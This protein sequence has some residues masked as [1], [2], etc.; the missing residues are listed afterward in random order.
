[1]RN[2]ERDR[3]NFILQGSLSELEWAP[4]TEEQITKELFKGSNPEMMMDAYEEQLGIKKKTEVKKNTKYK[5][6]V[7]NLSDDE[8]GALLDQFYNNP[9][10]FQLLNRADYWTH[11]G[12][13]KVLIEY[14]EDLDVRARK[15][16][17]E[18]R[19]A[20]KD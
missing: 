4:K 13:V 20:Q 19:K 5:H 14:L 9:E 16:K 3:E 8:H 10:Q 11:T 18:A 17:E 12:Q 15:E 7:L 6:I 1:M 2:S